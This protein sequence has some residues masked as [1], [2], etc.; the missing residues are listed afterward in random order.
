MVMAAGWRRRYL[1][2]VPIVLMPVLG[3][4][5]AKFA[6]KAFESRMAILVQEPGRLNPILSDISI[7]PNV[8]DRM[9]A[10]I[11]LLKSE[12]VLVGVL[13]D[14]GQLT[15][16]SNARQKDI[17]VG[18]L[19]GALTVQLVGSDLVELKIRGPKAVGLAQTLEAVGHRF[20]DRLVS[21]ERGAVENSESF[22]DRELAERTGE[23]SRA[24][25]AYSD[26]KALNADKLPALYTTNVTRLSAM[27]QKFEEKSMELAT[28]DASFEDIRARV[29]MLN[30][31]VGRLEEQIV[32]VSSEL[33]TLRGRY[34][35]EHS[36]VQGAERKLRRL[37]E[38]RANLLAQSRKTDGMDM[39]RLWNMAAG[40]VMNGDKNA[41]PLLVSQMQ[42]VQE[43]EAKRTALR[44]DVEQLTRAIN[45]LRTGIATFAPIEQQ[46][47]Q[48]ERAITAAREMHDMLAKRYQ[49]ARLTGSLGRFEAPE[50]IKI[51]DAPQ[52]PTA[53]VTPPGILFVI[54]GLVGGIILG[55]GLATA[56]EILD[57]RLRRAKDIREAFDLAVIAFLPRISAEAGV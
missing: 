15:S 31:V 12:H 6:P 8:K 23:L 32:Q 53:P 27:Q 10:L 33:A 17:L 45:E 35:D 34:T 48:L 50:R 16:Q 13:Q 54:G 18:Q 57:P 39:D 51:I 9:P 55:A 40:T 20:V 41:A 25:Q 4:V 42:R 2:C 22:L 46:Q 5:A 29:S 7:S 43:A 24:E 1:I 26:F 49:M 52:E 37:E 19:A 38:E 28:A 14:L 56:F 47:Q 21:P 11:A 44:K 3:G 30:P 36:E